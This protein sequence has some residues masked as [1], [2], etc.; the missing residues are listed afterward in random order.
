MSE[1]DLKGGKEIKGKPAVMDLMDPQCNRM[2]G[3]AVDSAV[4]KETR[5]RAPKLKDI[6]RIRAIQEDPSQHGTPEGKSRCH[7]LWK[8]ATYL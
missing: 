3:D 1:T 7:C 4:Q 2:E 5:P 6:R 8:L